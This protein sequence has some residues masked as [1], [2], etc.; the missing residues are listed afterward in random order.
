MKK[1]NKKTQLSFNKVFGDIKEKIAEITYFKIKENPAIKQAEILIQGEMKMGEKVIKEPK[2]KKVPDLHP[3]LK[4]FIAEQNQRWDQQFEFNHQ[5]N[6][7]WESQTELN[8]EIKEFIKDQNRRWDQQFEFNHQ[9]NKKWESQTELN[10]E[11]KEFIKDQNRRWDEQERKW[12]K[13]FEFNQQQNQKWNEQMQFN[14]QMLKTNQVV[15][16]SIQEILLRLERIESLPTIQK[17]L[18]DLK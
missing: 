11:I 9:Q 14:K 8:N 12:E 18:N 15:L 7:K 10:N 4:K 1:N 2:D 6:K 13:Q 5:Q 16:T 17:E 3:E